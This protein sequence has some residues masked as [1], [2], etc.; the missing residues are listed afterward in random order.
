MRD[1][2]LDVGV[3]M[4]ASGLGAL[5]YHDHSMELAQKIEAGINWF[6]AL[7]K[8]GRIEYQYREKMKPGDFGLELLIRLASKNKLVFVPVKHIPKGASVDL[9]DKAHFDSEDFKYVQTAYYTHCKILVSH[10]PHY[11]DAVC[12]ILRKIEVKVHSAQT[13]AA[14]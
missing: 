13:A 12:R 11:S 5:E 1:L 4:S 10:D 6:L 2:V 8:R 3:L 7:D 14:V 9:R